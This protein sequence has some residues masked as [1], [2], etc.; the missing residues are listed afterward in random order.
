[1]IFIKNLKYFI[2]KKILIT[3]PSGFNYEKKLT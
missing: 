3:V 2:N 1:M